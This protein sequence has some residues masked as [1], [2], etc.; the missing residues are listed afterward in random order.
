[1]AD[2]GDRK[3]PVEADT[4]T[5]YQWVLDMGS[6]Q[7]V[8]PVKEAVA[9]GRADRPVSAQ[10]DSAVSRLLAKVPLFRELPGKRL[11][12]FFRLCTPITVAQGEN[13]CT[14]DGPSEELFV[15]LSGELS[16]LMRDGLRVSIVQPVTTVGEMGFVTGKPRT[17]TLQA[18][19]PSSLLS[20]KNTHL[21][22]MLKSDPGMHL[23]VFRN[24]IE[25]LSARIVSVN[26][27]MRDHLLTRDDQ[28][29]RI[30][31]LEQRLQ[32]AVRLLADESGMSLD[33][34][35]ARIDGDLGDE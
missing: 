17:A 32:I 25:I 12:E 26:D 23:K 5:R 4:D 24:I 21:Q 20:I 22:T 3:Q 13:V 27:F 6:S 9:K 10:S 1:M 16:V 7:T 30:E 34:T 11:G 35:A 14:I 2:R 33:D 15:L 28:V 19:R 8:S 31:E 18:T 29:K